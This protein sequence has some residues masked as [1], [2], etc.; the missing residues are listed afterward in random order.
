[1]N[2]RRFVFS[3]GAGID[4]EVTRWVDEHQPLKA[5][6]GYLSFTYAALASYLSR[7]RGA[8]PRLK[9]EAAG[10]RVAGVSALVQNA[11]PYTYLRSRPLRICEE[12]SID[13]GTLSAMVMKRANALDA[14]GIVRRIFSE[15]RRLCRHPQAH[16]FTRLAEARVSAIETDGLPLPFPLEVDGDYIGEFT[17]ARYAVEPS[18][19]AIVA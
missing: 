14:P 12:V 8:P 5:R 13:G 19:L 9:L 6:A 3:S 10:E 15:H 2:G 7:Y 18:A 17:V 4:A 11:D 16:S 1:V